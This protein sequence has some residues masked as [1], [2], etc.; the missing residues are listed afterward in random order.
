M[1]KIVVILMAACFAFCGFSCDV[2]D[3]APGATLPETSS[4]TTVPET[5]EVWPSIKPNITYNGGSMQYSLNSKMYSHWA[6]VNGDYKWLEEGKKLLTGDDWYYFEERFDASKTAFV[7]MDPWIDWADDYLNE[8]FGKITKEKTLPLMQAAAKAGHKV[9][10][11]TGSPKYSTYNTKIDTGLERMVSA[12]KA[13]KLYHE[14]YTKESFKA[15]LDNLG[16]ETLIYTGYASNLCVLVRELGIVQMRS[17]GKRIFFV[18]ECSGAIERADTWDSGLVH[19]IS[20][21]VISQSQARLLDFSA[22]TEVY[23]TVK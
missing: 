7:V 4:E 19:E 1:K 22:M 6:Y 18:P 13:V 20:T 15:Y 16:I 23:N 5:K 12:K 3:G 14:D 11:L 8:Y 9:I 17:M 21:L 10:I 2:P